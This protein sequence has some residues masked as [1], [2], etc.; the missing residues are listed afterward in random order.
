MPAPTNITPETATVV[1]AL[2]FTETIDVTDAPTGSGYASTCD[3]NQ[4]HAIW[5]AWTAQARD[6]YVAVGRSSSPA[7]SVAG[8]V[9]IW[10]GALGSLTQLTVSPQDFCASLA[11]HYFSVPVVPGSTYY[12]Q[13]TT[14]ANTAPAGLVVVTMEEQ[15]FLTAASGSVVIADDYIGFPAAVIDRSTGDFLQFVDLFAGEYAD[16][17]PTGQI[18][19]QTDDTHVS[20]YTA[21]RSLIA[22]VEVG[23]G[24]FIGGIKSD[25]ANLFYVVSVHPSVGPKARISTVSKAGVLGGTTWDLPADADSLS[26]TAVTRDGATFYYAPYTASAVVHAYDLINDTA[27]PDLHTNFTTERC[28]IDGDGFV[29]VDGN[30]LIGY[31]S[32]LG[33]A[34]GLVRRFD[35]AGTVLNTYTLVDGTYTKLDH[36]CIGE[37][38]PSCLVAWC[39]NA[40]NTASRVRTIQL[41]DGSVLESFIVPMT[42]SSGEPAGAGVTFAISD[43]CPIFVTTSEWTIPYS[44]TTYPMRRLRRWLLPSHDNLRMFVSRLEILAQTGVGLTTG[45]GSDPQVM[46]RF[47]TDGG[48]TWSNERWMGLGAIGAYATRVYTTRLGQG[49]QFVGEIVTSDPVI[50]AFLDCYV[51][52]EPGES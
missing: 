24:R 19:V 34:D 2:P 23:A 39:F 18:C 50:T 36:F 15:P 46:F 31:C 40:A 11:D 43:S 37:D 12:I 30:I 44:T 3:T 27:L 1:S 45:Q 14:T 22:T 7:A 48:F 17:M 6:I 32:A 13:V 26:A 16:T 47:S 10:E 42:S 25:R 38:D 33:G 28:S 9:S 35:A 8:K 5:Y 29:D 51:D 41:S 21:S 20:V 52:I 49:R 4:Y